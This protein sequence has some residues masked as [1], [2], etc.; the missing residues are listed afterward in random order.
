[1]KSALRKIL[2]GIVALVVLGI[3]ALLVGSLED[4]YGTMLPELSDVA[5]RNVEA[6]SNIVGL[7][8]AV[9]LAVMT[10]KNLATKKDK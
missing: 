4:L 10:Y 3:I 8:V 1:M 2:A 5:L 9:V 6:V 7:M